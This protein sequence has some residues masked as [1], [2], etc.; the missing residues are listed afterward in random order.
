MCQ[1]CIYDL[2]NGA[3]NGLIQ[4]VDYEKDEFEWRHQGSAG[5][6]LSLAFQPETRYV[7]VPAVCSR[8]DAR[9]TACLLT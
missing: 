6:I 2:C 9:H 7:S 3:G 1:A 4:L 8:C 5:G